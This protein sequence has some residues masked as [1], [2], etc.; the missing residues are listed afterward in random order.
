MN[1]NHPIA[2][3]IAITAPGATDFD[4]KIRIEAVDRTI[5][6]DSEL[7]T[8]CHVL[9]LTYDLIVNDEKV[10]FYNIPDLSGLSLINICS[11]AMS[12]SNCVVSNQTHTN[13]IS[14]VPVESDF[15]DMIIHHV[16]G[17]AGA[18][19]VTYRNPRDFN[20]IDIQLLDR[21]L[22]PTQLQKNIVLTFRL[23]IS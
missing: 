14:S 16:D 6:L 9:G 15:G 23:L 10:A 5:E 2:T 8:I 21:N 18:D 20:I 1:S 3:G 4:Q 19:S 13:I 7:S 12:D 11:A 22:Q 17:I